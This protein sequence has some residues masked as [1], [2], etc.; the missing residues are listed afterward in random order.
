MLCNNNNSYYNN[1]FFL[2]LQ[3]MISWIPA[4]PLQQHLRHFTAIQTQK[5]LSHRKMHL[6]CFLVIIVWHWQ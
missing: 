1:N 4:T 6:L 2:L 5:I 3:I